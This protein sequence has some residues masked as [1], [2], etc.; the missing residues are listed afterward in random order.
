MRKIILIT[1]GSRSG[2]STYAER[3][4][5]TYAETPIYIATARVTDEEFRLRVETHRER[6]GNKWI[7]IEEDK[8]ISKH[9]VAG[10]CVLVDCLTLWTSNFFF[11][12]ANNA[13][14]TDI[15]TAAEGRRL[16]NLTL[17]QIKKELEQIISQ[18]AV[19]IFVTNEIGSGGVSAN[20]VQ[21]LFTDLIGWVNQYVAGQAHEVYHMVCGIPVKIK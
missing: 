9:N 1:G 21:R 8:Y 17:E 13:G 11:D 3:L 12:T 4:A 16:I 2:K 20:T 15:E 18:E 10:H 19:F 14:I 6:R 7:N 5:L